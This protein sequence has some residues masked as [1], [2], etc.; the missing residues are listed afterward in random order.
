MG[1]DPAVLNKQAEHTRNMN[2][3]KLISIYLLHVEDEIHISK[4]ASNIK[5][6]KYIIY[7]TIK[8]IATKA[9]MMTRVVY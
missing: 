1:R 7:F 3:T 6:K 4:S 8:A 2:N 5:Y 9:R